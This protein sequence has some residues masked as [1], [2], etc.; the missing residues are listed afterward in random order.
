MPE[1]FLPLKDLTLLIKGAGEM[2]TGV[3]HRLACSGFKIL[4][5]EIAEPLAVRR[6]VSFCEAV[7]EGTKVVEGVTARRVATR[8]EIEEAW[9]DGELPIAVDPAC[10]LRAVLKPDVLIDAILAK[11]NKG[12]RLDDAPLVIALGPGFR[13]GRD[14]H[15]V[16]E[17]NRG[18]K[19][20][21]VI[22]AGEAEPNTGIPGEIAGF[23]WERVLRAPC[24]GRF[25]SRRS[26]GERASRGEIVAEVEGAPILSNITGVMR[27][28]LR[29]GLR[30]KE[31]MKVGDVDPRGIQEYC[32]TIS[33]KARAIGGSVLEAILRKYNR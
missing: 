8:E 13:A 33:E 32:F 23:T 15:F 29:D 20:G 22:E 5:T 6:A 21:R 9:Q 18:H 4:L 30:V 27:G 24:A 11:E 14:A 26:I 12:T 7:F 2:A 25:Q 19:L 3:A 10:S 31:G 17:T 1:K 16:I 28:M